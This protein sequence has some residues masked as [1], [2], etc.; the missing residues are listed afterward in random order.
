MELG[1]LQSQGSF[2]AADLRIERGYHS[3]VPFALCI[4]SFLHKIPLERQ[5]APKTLKQSSPTS[6]DLHVS[7]SFHL[8]QRTK[9]GRTS[10]ISDCKDAKENLSNLIDGTSM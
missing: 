3:P 9:R 2:C 8:S 1:K 10:G 6:D 5:F 4:R 7:N